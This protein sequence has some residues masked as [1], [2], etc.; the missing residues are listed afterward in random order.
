MDRVPKFSRGPKKQVDFNNQ[1]GDQLFALA[2]GG[3]NTSSRTYRAL[4]LFQL[5]EAVKMPSSS[6]TTGQADEPDC[7]W[8]ENAQPVVCTPWSD[9][10]GDGNTYD[11][12][13]QDQTQVVFF[14]S[15][16][17][18][19][20]GDGGTLSCTNPGLSVGDRLW[21]GWNIQSGRWEGISKQEN[22]KCRRCKGT[23]A[24]AL[25]FG[26]ATCT[27]NNVL[28]TDGLSNP[29]STSTVSG[30]LNTFHFAALSAAQARMEILIAS[31]VSDQW[32]LVQVE[33]QQYAFM[34]DID[35]GT[36]TKKVRTIVGM[37]G[38]ETSSSFSLPSFSLSSYSVNVMTNL[39]DSASGAMGTWETVWV[40]GTGTPTSSLVLPAGSCS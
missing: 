8:V 4:W 5:T 40:L 36:S 35:F 1:V 21:A 30:V 38:S 9:N 6:R 18:G 11:A 33:Q 16:S 13:S 15:Y 31:G 23:L 37:F 29:F 7:P 14:P 19:F 26:D 2:A 20:T 27:L 12:S 17:K 3:D 10:S 22:N 24:Q 28:P 34:E 39:A 32:E 25:G